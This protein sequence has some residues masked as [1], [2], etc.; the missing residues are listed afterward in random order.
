M[1]SEVNIIAAVLLEAQYLTE[2]IKLRCLSP[3]VKI[4]TSSSSEQISE[5]T[6]YPLRITM[7]HIKNCLIFFFSKVIPS[8]EF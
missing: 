3:S 5:P 8:Q 4:C 7:A 2:K 6:Q 1:L